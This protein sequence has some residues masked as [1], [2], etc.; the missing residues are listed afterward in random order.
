M[1]GVPELAGSCS[2]GSAG[3]RVN[4]AGSLKLLW[5]KAVSS[6]HPCGRFSLGRSESQCS[7]MT[8][9][10]QQDFHD[11][12]HVWCYLILHKKRKQSVG[13]NV[14]PRFVALPLCWL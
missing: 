1:E 9:H 11:S 13:F 10:N 8:G 2:L 4:A 7:L 14:S 6:L 12:I 5:L 3:L